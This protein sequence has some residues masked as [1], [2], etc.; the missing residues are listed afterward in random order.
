MARLAVRAVSSE[1][2]SVASADFPETKENTGNLAGSDIKYPQAGSRK[3]LESGGSG[4][5]F[6]ADPNKEFF[7]REQRNRQRSRDLR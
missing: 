7:P 2:V 1:P 5:N 3:C 6:P 4:F